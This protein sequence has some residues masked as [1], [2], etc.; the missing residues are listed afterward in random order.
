M[1][2]TRQLTLAEIEN[3]VCDVAARQ[4]AIPRQ[5]I[6]RVSRMMEDL[7]C[8]SLDAVELFVALEDHFDV[9]IP[10]SKQDP[11][12]KSI[13]TRKG[14]CVGDIAEIVYVRLG[15][16]KPDRSF[17]KW[18]RPP[19]KAK[20]EVSSDTPFCQ[21]SGAWDGNADAPLFEAL[22]DIGPV[23][24]YRRRTDGMRCLA[25][26]AAQVEIGT[27]DPSYDPDSRPQHSVY[28]DSFLI[29]AEVVS[30]TAYCRFLNSI[31]EVP[32]ETLLDWFVLTED[33]DRG[34]H[35]LVEQG[36]AGWQPVRGCERL[37]MML[38]SWYG[39]NAYSLWANQHDW[40]RCRCEGESETQSFLPTEAQWEYAAR[41]ANFQT[42]PWGDEPATD[43]LIR[44]GR[45]TIGETYTATT[46]PMMDVNTKCGMSPFGMH[47][48][49]GNVWQ[50]CRDWYDE[51]FYSTPQA[52]LRNAVN[53]TSS[54]VRAE[55]GGSWVGPEEL[56]RSSY[57]RG[58]EPLARGRC[59]GFRCVGYLGS[60]GVR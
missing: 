53:Q 39:A 21:L 5:K 27:N 38:V 12:V 1:T 14:L 59:V 48:A 56:C 51:K 40:R 29:D 50:W 18:K 24:Q 16:G 13:F 9:T 54:G 36:K 44:Y 10:I 46:L 55:R 26:P 8:D 28:L 47:H 35:M 20:E 7:H 22:D 42:Y 49:V 15:S 6:T 3:I 34:P 60:D 31:G 11:V 41:G 17:W 37:P 2:S 30:T 58:R 43:E 19:S 57:R 4:L 33:D 25:I 23:P 52:T 45:H 32:C